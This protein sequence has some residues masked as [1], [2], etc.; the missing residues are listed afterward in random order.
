[1]RTP[2]SQKSL[3]S[4]KINAPFPLVWAADSYAVPTR[5]GSFATL[6]AIRRAW[7]FGDIGR[8]PSRLVARQQLGR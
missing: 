5:S 1:L 2:P 7:L 6:A 8:D 3:Q 4:Q